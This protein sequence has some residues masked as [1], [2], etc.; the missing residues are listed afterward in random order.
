MRSHK[1]RAERHPRA[2]ALTAAQRRQIGAQI[3]AA[4]KRADLSTADLASRLGLSVSAVDR[5]EAGVIAPGLAVSLALCRVLG[6]TVGD[7][8]GGEVAP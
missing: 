2:S 1:K 4:R 3:R 8:V 6:I 7:L 5:Y